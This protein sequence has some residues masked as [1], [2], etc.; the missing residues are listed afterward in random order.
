MGPDQEQDPR[1]VERIVRWTRA[2][3]NWTPRCEWMPRH[4]QRSQHTA[5]SHASALYAQRIAPTQSRAC[6]PISRVPHTPRVLK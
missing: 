6:P 5:R 4:Q 3:V 1:D 2:T